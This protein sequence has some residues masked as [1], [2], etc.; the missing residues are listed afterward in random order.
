VTVPSFTVLEFDK[1]NDIDWYV[2]EYSLRL[3]RNNQ[4]EAIKLN[5]RKI[6]KYNLSVYL[7]L[8]QG[9]FARMTFRGY[10]IS[11]RAPQTMPGN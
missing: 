7:M 5:N 8:R 11:V 9:K 3:F 6:S 4:M 10:D 2:A 1:N